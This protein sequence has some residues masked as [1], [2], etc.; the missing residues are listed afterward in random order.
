MATTINWPSVL[1]D[2]PQT[3]NEVD[4][5]STVRSEVDVGVAKVRRRYT[6]ELTSISASLTLKRSEYDN[7][8]NFY[9]TTLKDGLYSFNYKHPYTGVMLEIRFVNPPTISMNS[10]AFQVTF[11]WE[12][13]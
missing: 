8:I 1:P 5:P 12:T 9:R 4:K 3:W 7:L 6:R 11:E 2:C 10:K 13:L